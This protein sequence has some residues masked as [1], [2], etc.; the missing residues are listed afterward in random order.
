[1]IQRGLLHKKGTVA[2]ATLIAAPSFTL[3]KDK[4]CDPEMHS[5]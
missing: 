3:N 2:D 1:M 5:S 4:A